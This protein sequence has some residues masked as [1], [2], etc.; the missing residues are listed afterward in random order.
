MLMNFST[1]KNYQL[2]QMLVGQT[3]STQESLCSNRPKKCTIHCLVSQHPEEVLMVGL[4]VLRSVMY[5]WPRCDKT[6][7]RGF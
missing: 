1:E 3:A 7:L 2:P 6:C 5:I 4:V